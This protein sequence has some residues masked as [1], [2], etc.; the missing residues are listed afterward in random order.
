VERPYSLLVLP[1][2][3]L[4]SPTI[5]SVYGGLFGDEQDK[6]QCADLLAH[7][8]DN[9]TCINVL[10][11]GQTTGVRARHII[12]GIEKPAGE[13]WTGDDPQKF[14]MLLDEDVLANI[15]DCG[16]GFPLVVD[17]SRFARY[18]PCTPENA[19][20][21][22]RFVERIEAGREEHGLGEFVYHM[23]DEPNN[24]Y[25]YDD[26]R[27][28]R[29]YGIGHVAYFGRVLRELGVRQYVTVNSTNRGY[30]VAEKAAAET[31]I[32]CPNSISDPS[33]L[34]RWWKRGAEVWLYNYAGDGA[35]KGAMRSTYGF[36]SLSIGATGVTVWTHRNFVRRV[37]SDGKYLDSSPWEAA[38][39]GIDDARYIETLLD[40]IYMAEKA[41]GRDAELAAEAEHVLNGILMA[42]PVATDAKVRFEEKH[43]ASEWNKWRWIIAQNIMML[44]DA[45]ER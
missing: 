39:E 22:R 45:R 28:G 26:G 42:Y 35:C 11:S 43:D 6:V 41:G 7:G 9:F 29:R 12:W 4:Q 23:V 27:Y 17:L 20:L 31:D 36:Y 21:F 19:E 25:T 8:F 37:R 30:D 10:A 1:F 5:A 15:S 16:L 13:G 32:W 33:Y 2:S 38:R 34:S 3:L 18:L 14:E 44:R 40:E 24:H